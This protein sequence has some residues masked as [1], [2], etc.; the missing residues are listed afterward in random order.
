MRAQRRPPGPWFY[1]F[2]WIVMMALRQEA[3]LVDERR[4]LFG[5]MPAGLAYQA[6]YSLLAAAVMAWLVRRAWPAHLEALEPSGDG[7]AERE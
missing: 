5:V 2:L 3:W 4:L 6:A 7:A 1:A